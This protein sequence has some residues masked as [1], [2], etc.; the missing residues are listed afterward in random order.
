MTSSKAKKQQRL[1]A[2]LGRLTVRRKK[3]LQQRRE[4][5]GE[6]EMERERDKIAGSNKALLLKI[7]REQEN[8][9]LLIRL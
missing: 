9:H 7:K 4:R 1:I 6:R 8:M 2:P 5:D 3:E